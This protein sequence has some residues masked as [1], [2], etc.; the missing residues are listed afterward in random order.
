MHSLLRYSYYHLLHGLNCYYHI[1]SPR[2]RI[3]ASQESSSPSTLTQPLLRSDDD[4][5]EASEVERSEIQHISTRSS[6]KISRNIPIA[7]AYTAFVFAGRSV[8]SQS[9]LSTFVFLLRNEDYRAVGFITAVMGLAQLVTSFPSGF[10]ADRYRRDTLLRVASVVALLAIASTLY[11]IFTNDYRSLV[12]GLAVWGSYWGI[13]NTSMS[14]LFADSI[15]TGMRSKY[16]TQRSLLVN[17]GFAT[18][19]A[20]SLILFAVLGDKWGIRDCAIVLAVGQA[21]CLPAIVLLCFMSDDH[22]I[23]HEEDAVQDDQDGDRHVST[24][25]ADD[26]PISDEESLNYCG[27]WFLPKSRRTPILIALADLISGLAS[28]MSIRYFPIFFVENLDMGPVLVQVLYVL[29]PV[30]LAGCMKLAQ[31][32]STSFGRCRVSVAF[33]WIGVVLMWVLVAAYKLH[34]PRWLV[35][36]I[37]IFRTAFINSTGALTRSVLMDHVPPSERGRWA[38]LESLNMFSW[39]GSA[40]LGGYLVGMI[41]MVPLFCTTAVIQFLATFPLVILSGQEKLEGETGDANSDDVNENALSTEPN[42]AISSSL[43]LPLLPHA[44]NQDNE[45]ES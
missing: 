25:E 42:A 41:G 27:L 1:M 14:A 24:G 30:F 10:L 7:L 22:V 5:D 26:E 44:E 32:L 4:D 38:A 34:Q 31:H 29:S 3:T 18:G 33:K 11:A 21:I 20:V 6:P 8:W 9:V 39:S 28:G 37:Y 45:D 40:A 16:F 12:V 2:S 19:P 13:S 23:P 36:A 15:P 35:C 43:Q 17:V